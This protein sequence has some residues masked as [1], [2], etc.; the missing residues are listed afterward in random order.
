MPMATDQLILGLARDESLT[1]GL[2]DVEAQQLMNWLTDWAEL[3][4]DAARSDADA[5]R[6]ITRLSHRARAIARFVLWWY[7]PYQRCAAIQL[8]ATERFEW[9]LPHDEERF[10]PVE[11]MEHILNWESQHRGQ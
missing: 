7:Q 4:A 10:T 1:R 6:L 2:G 5:K 11:M 3:L 8:A 9:P